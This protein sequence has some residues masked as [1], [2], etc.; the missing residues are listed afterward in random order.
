MVVRNNLLVGGVSVKQIPVLELVFF[1]AQI[2]SNI[3][4]FLNVFNV[5]SDTK[6]IANLISFNIS[7]AKGR[8]YPIKVAEVLFTIPP[9][10]ILSNHENPMIE[11]LLF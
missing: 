2:V 10:K 6:I 3:F 9:F 8:W 1:A 11:F 4:C 5:Q 7:C